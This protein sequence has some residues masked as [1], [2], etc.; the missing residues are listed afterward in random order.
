MLLHSVVVAA[1]WVLPAFLLWKVSRKSGQSQ[2]APVNRAVPKVNVRIV[3]YH[4]DGVLVGALLNA[5]SKDPMGDGQPLPEDIQKNVASELAKVPGAFSV[6]A[7]ADDVA[8]GLCNCLEGFSTFKCKRLI[9]IHDCFVLPDHR[10][11][12]AVD[13]MLNEVERVATARGACKITL[14]VLSNN[15]RAQRV[16]NRNGFEAY[17]LDPAAGHALFWQKVLKSPASSKRRGSK[18]PARR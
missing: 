4:K 2:K 16:Y 15:P 14:E 6:L 3:D 5:Y 13:A 9:N 1:C 7:F 10:G 17:Q 18:S 11:L 12:G 8:V